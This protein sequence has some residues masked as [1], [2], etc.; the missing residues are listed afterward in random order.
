MLSQDVAAD[1]AGLPLVDFQEPQRWAEGE[2]CKAATQ[3]DRRRS[4]SGKVGENEV[5]KETLAIQNVNSIPNYKKD[6]D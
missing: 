4:D 3:L 5:R 6:L 2:S 1:V